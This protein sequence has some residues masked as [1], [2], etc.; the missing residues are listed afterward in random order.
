MAIPRF[1]E[2]LARGENKPAQLKAAPIKSAPSKD[3]PPPVSKSM[4]T[5]SVAGIFKNDDKHR[6]SKSRS[7]KP[8]K[9]IPAHSKTLTSRGHAKDSTSRRAPNTKKDVLKTH[10]RTAHTLAL[11]FEGKLPYLISTQRSFSLETTACYK[12]EVDASY[13]GALEPVHQDLLHRLNGNSSNAQDDLSHHTLIKDLELSKNMVLDLTAPLENDVL[14][15]RRKNVHGQI[16]R[17]QIP[18]GTTVTNFESKLFEKQRELEDLWQEWDDVQRQIVEL[19]AEM[20]DDDES[21]EVAGLNN[22]SST[23][24]EDMVTTLRAEIKTLGAQALKEFQT[25]AKD[26]AEKRKKEDL[27]FNSL[28][29]SLI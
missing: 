16:T 9:N 2:M 25:E 22:T 27:V 15:I 5:V 20:L 12:Q 26:D 14:T 6:V 28:M 29:A 17:E 19:G 1:S 13:S 3:H 23:E 21:V 18:L 8:T 24:L 7:I 11:A 4:K 10:T